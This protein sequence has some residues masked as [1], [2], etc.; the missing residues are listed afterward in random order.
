MWHYVAW[1]MDN[2]I[3]Q[4]PTTFN[5]RL[6]YIK[7]MKAAGSSKMLVPIYK[8]IQYHI[9][10]DCNVNTHDRENLTYTYR[11]S[12]HITWDTHVELY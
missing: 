3:S 10:E 6:P 2:N 12:C 11:S 9:S 7:D 1:W 8:I 4:K 5:F